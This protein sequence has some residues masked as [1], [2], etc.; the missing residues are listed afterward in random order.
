MFE[1]WS[2]GKAPPYSPMTTALKPGT[3]DL[4]GISWSQYGGKTGIWRFIRILSQTD[5]KATVC[6]NAK[7]A[8]LYPDAVH[9]LH[10]RRHEIAA[11]SYTQD[12]ILPYLSP[13]EEAEVIQRCSRMIEK[14]V[15]TRPVGWFSPVAAPSAHTAA[16]LAEAGFQW[17]GDYNDTDLPYSFETS[18]GTLVAISHSDFTDNRVLR[19]SPRDFFQVYKDTFDFLYKHEK[20]SVIN[21]TVHAHFG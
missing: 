3:P 2:E 6:L 13:E 21:L 5:I 20:P 11:H 18:K 16:F 10:R 9:E 8:E 15:G 19:G 7:A 14:A 17:H 12:L 4:L 1:V